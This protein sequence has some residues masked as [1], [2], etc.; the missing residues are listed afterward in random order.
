M[1][2]SNDRTMAKRTPEERQRGEEAF[3]A[4][5]EDRKKEQ[6]R[7]EYWAER[8]EE[9]DRR[10]IEKDKRRHREQMEKDRQRVQD[11]K[12]DD[13]LRQSETPEQTHARHYAEMKA[14][15][16]RMQFEKRTGTGQYG[17]YQRAQRE[18]E[19]SKKEWVETKA[20]YGRKGAGMPGAGRPT[21]KP[22][23]RPKAT[24]DDVAKRFERRFGRKPGKGARRRLRGKGRADNRPSL[25]SPEGVAMMSIAFAFDFVP[26]IFVLILDLAFG[27]G[28]VVSWTLDIL[29]TMIIGGWMYYRGGSMQGKGK[30]AKFLKRRVPWMAG[31]YVPILGSIMPFWVINTFLF[32]KK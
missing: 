8:R 21:E 24:R 23:K 16:E 26:P 2:P 11:W 3:R 28:E 15:N 22:P 1:S 12:R 18:L 20:K 29:A 17:E 6:E 25:M 32:L 31:E 10:Y 13:R 5:E 19:K 27:L 14:A 7:K 30:F 9:R 4:R